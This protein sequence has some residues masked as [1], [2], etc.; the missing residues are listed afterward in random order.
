M[1]RC[2]KQVALVA[3]AFIALIAVGG[4]TAMQANINGED[5]GTDSTSSFDVNNYLKYVPELK[6]GNSVG[7]SI[8]FDESDAYQFLKFYVDSFEGFEESANEYNRIIIN[9]VKTSTTLDGFS[10]NICEQIASKNGDDVDVTV[11]PKMSARIAFTFDVVGTA[12]SPELIVKVVG[13]VD[14]SVEGNL[15]AD[16]KKTDFTFSAKIP[17]MIYSKVIFSN[18]KIPQS[19]DAMVKTT[20]DISG[21]M[22]EGGETKSMDEKTNIECGLSAS[23]VDGITISEVNSLLDGTSPVMNKE[24]Y[25]MFYSKE[26]DF[27]VSSVAGNITIDLT[28]LKLN[29]AISDLKLNSNDIDVMKIKGQLKDLKKNILPDYADIKWIAKL[30]DVDEKTYAQVKVVATPY[31]EQITGIL[32]DIWNHSANEH[33][34]SYYIDW[35]DNKVHGNQK[36]SISSKVASVPKISFDKVDIKDGSFC[37]SGPSDGLTVTNYEYYGAENTVVKA[38][39]P[40]LFCGMNVTEIEGCSFSIPH[41]CELKLTISESMRE[42]PVRILRG[43]RTY[44]GAGGSVIIYDEAKKFGIIYDLW[45]KE[46]NVLENN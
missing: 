12:D 22:I 26:G 2:N 5:G 23:I 16:G 9:A 1:N 24:F 10:A 33:L 43:E 11:S 8:E 13:G 19:I 21:T 35:N 31:L 32:K 37:F 17:V 3:V 30:F 38:T 29:D 18:E 4:L 27:V 39:I 14:S 25:F 34:T 46:G 41:G 44:E 45:M 20:F 7:G 15:I 6:P 28:M 42:V 40:E 36:D